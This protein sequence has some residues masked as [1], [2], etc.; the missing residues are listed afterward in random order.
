MCNHYNDPMLSYNNP[1]KKLNR[2][3]PFMYSNYKC[4]LLLF[5]TFNDT[6]YCNEWLNM[7]FNVI[8]TSRQKMLMIKRSNKFI[9]GML[10]TCNK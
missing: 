1:H 2:A 7:F 3:R 9:C 6:N 10:T 5:K 8:N 4:A